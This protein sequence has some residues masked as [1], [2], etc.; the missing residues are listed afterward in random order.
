MNGGTATDL[1]YSNQWQVVEERL[2]GTTAPTAQYVWSP[3]YVD[4]MIERDTAG[5]PRL[6]V[7]QDAHWNVTALVSTSGAVQERYAYD[8]YG[9]ATVLNP[10]TEV[11]LPHG[12]RWPSKRTSLWESPLLT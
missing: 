3:V 2:S 5:G 8:P 10:T 9:K 1:Y 11:G 4:A 12:E 7:Q 6:Y